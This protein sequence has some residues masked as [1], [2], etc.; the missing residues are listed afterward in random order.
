MR[1]V[2]WIITMIAF[3]ACASPAP[4]PPPTVAPVVP[5]QATPAPATSTGAAP[6]GQPASGWD[7]VVAA[8]QSEGSL[9]INNGAGVSGQQV[10][11]TFQAA[12]PWLQVQATTMSA[13]QFTPRVLTEQRNGLYAW[14]L[15]LGAGFNNVERSLAPAGAVGDVRPLLADLPADVK[16]DSKWAGGFNWYRSDASPDSLVTELPVTYGVFVNRDQIP[17]SE[18]SS[19]T[20]L[21]DPMFK[22]KLVIYDPSVAN[23]GSQG[24][25][26]I[27]Y[28]TDET[29]INKL[30]IDQGA[31]QTSDTNQAAQFL[32]EGRYPIALGIS[33][34][35]LLPFQS[36]G[37]GKNVEPLKDVAN[38][39]V[40]AGGFTVLQNAPH[41]NAI[42]VFLSWFLSRDGQDAWNK[43]NVLSAS[44]RLDLTVVNQ[45]ALPD[46]AHLDQYKVVFDT[47]SGN[48]L[49]DRTLALVAADK[50]Q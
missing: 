21:T 23:A 11:D 34:S 27:L 38:Q 2:V 30:L 18:L 41:P 46:Y 49:L 10:L 47:P 42:K 4:A 29:F 50:Q 25:A 14:D 9:V 6:A 3:A 15:L 16:D 12:Y 43:S 1:T 5:T 7:A 31:V 45:D 24:L 20:Q 33:S 13:S 48:Q 8:A 26:N 32:T 44:R 22:G 36:Q 17:T 40:R 39:Y 37:V 19:I 28:H 35:S